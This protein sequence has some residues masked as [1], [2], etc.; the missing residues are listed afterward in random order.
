MANQEHLAIARKGV[1]AWNAWREANPT[2][3]PDLSGALFADTDQFVGPPDP[4]NPRGPKWSGINLLRANLDKAVL[5]EAE[6]FDADLR[7]ANLSRACIRNGLLHRANL[8]GAKLEFANCFRSQ[9]DDSKLI[10]ARMSGADLGKT[11]LVRCSLRGA[12]LSGVNLAGATLG[13]TCL[14]NTLLAGATGLSEC[15]FVM[16]CSIDFRTLARSWPV[17]IQFLRGCGLPD[18]VIEYLPSLVGRPL[19]F[20]SCFIS[21]SSDDAEF[22]ERLHADLQDQGVRCWFAPHDVRGGKKLHE[23]IDQAI[24][25]H[26]KLL[27]ILS[28]AS[29][30]SE[31]VKTETYKAR[32]REVKEKRR[33][34][35][36]IRLCGFDELRDWACCDDT[37]RDIAREVREYFVP[38]F[39]R[40][41]EHDLY[42]KAFRRLLRDLKSEEES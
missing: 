11:D 38:D 20:H 8:E 13:E 3:I 31:W 37:G 25:F 6:L 34:L 35:F 7:Y 1:A 42:A 40:W 14:G 12:D 15:R 41:K 23:Q 39:S 4:V 10:S 22:A 16:P 17:S 9:F 33:V 26:D 30:A 2:V 36:P 19:E 27:L 21:Y 18:E 24:R 32:Q 28:P 5:D 29:M